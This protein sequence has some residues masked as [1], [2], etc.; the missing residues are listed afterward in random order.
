MISA[1]FKMARLLATMRA[2]SRGRAGQRAAN[3]AIGRGVG[4]A[5]RRLWR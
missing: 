4:R 3:I 2:V 1:L 5:S